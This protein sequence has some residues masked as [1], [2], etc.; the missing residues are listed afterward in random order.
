MDRGWLRVNDG[1]QGEQV[2]KE[3]VGMEEMGW[4]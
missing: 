1:S 4:M 3:G 2:G